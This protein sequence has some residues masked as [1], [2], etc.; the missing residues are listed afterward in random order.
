MRRLAACLAAAAVLAALPPA[1]PPAPAARSGFS[2]ALE[3]L[4][5]WMTGT[6]SSAAQAARDTSFRDVR[7]V[8][9]PV[10]RDRSDARWFYVEQ[11][12]AGREDRPYRQRVYRLMENEQGVFESAVFTLPA[13]ERFAGRGR[14]REP[15]AGL[16]PD[17]LTERRGCAV[18]LRRAGAAYRGGTAGRG[19]PSELRGAAYATSEVVIERDR[20]RTL[21]RGFDAAGAQ[22]WGSTRGAYE[23]VRVRAGR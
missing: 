1:A 9:V 14:E 7:L 23:F 15:L 5:A 18:Y 11:A 12:L 17:S 22:V 21:D 20:M 4:A 2:P 6:F 19:C 10:W 3:R 16:T 13:P 8:I